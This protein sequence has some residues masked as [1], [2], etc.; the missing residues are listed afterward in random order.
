VASVS[1]ALALISWLII[2]IR[3]DVIIKGWVIILIET[4]LISVLWYY[5]LIVRWSNKVL[6]NI[7]NPISFKPRIIT[8]NIRQAD[9]IN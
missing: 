6:L 3:G 1:L 7:I 2:I 8:Y 9:N 5:S 4:M